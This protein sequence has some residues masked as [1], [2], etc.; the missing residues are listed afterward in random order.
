[1]KR[2]PDQGLPSKTD[3]VAKARAA[4]GETLPDWVLELAEFASKTSGAQAAKKIGY[5]GA[6]VTHVIGNKYTGDLVRVADKVRGALM[7]VE[8]TCPVYGAIGRDR[9]LD[10][11][12]LP[13]A[14]TNA[15]RARCFHACRGG[16]P[17]S[18]IN[19]AEV[20]HGA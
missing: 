17:H 19:G 18:R 15:L 3:F 2:G 7:G 13:F 16:C 9:C 8:V 11:Q 6:V 12:K 14:A 1:M 20:R 4:W 5:S 10:N